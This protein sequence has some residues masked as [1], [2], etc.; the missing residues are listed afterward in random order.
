[1]IGFEESAK[2]AAS[3][4]AGNGIVNDLLRELSAAQLSL[5]ESKIRPAHVAGL[6]NL[7]EAGVV[8]NNIAKGVFVTMAQTGEMPEVIIERQ[9]LE[10]IRLTPVN[11]NAGS[12]TRS[13]QIRRPC[14][15]IQGW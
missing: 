2:L 11:L 6:V 10:A 3:P 14:R 4:A 5:I 7:V 9:R 1:M 8:S 15:R 12:P 13:R